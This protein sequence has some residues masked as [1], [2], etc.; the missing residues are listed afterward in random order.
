M[1]Q[2]EPGSDGNE[3]VLRIPQSFST[4]GT[5]SSDCLVSYPGHSF[6]GGLTPLQRCSQ[7]ILQP[8][9]TGQSNIFVYTNKHIV[10]RSSR[11]IVA[12]MLDC[13]I[14]A[15]SNSSHAII[16]FWTN[17]QG[18]GMNHLSI[19]LWVKQYCYCTFYKD[20]FVIT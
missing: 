3:G 15:S 14:I 8:Q 4:A 19:Q 18:K 1:G 9:L 20:G 12:D 2:S 11:N 17:I 7:C 6:G 10:E 16:Y 13:D 5:S